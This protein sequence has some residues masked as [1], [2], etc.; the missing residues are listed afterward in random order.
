MIPLTGAQVKV[1]TFILLFRSKNNDVSPSYDEIAKAI[2]AKSKS[3][4]FRLVRSI[5]ERGHIRITPNRVRSIEVVEPKLEVYRK[6]LEKIDDL[7]SIVARQA[8]DAGS[9]TSVQIGVVEAKKIAMR[10]LH[11]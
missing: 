3:S 2:G 5:E 11:G 6:A 1:I 4:V 10:A 9:A 8:H 7:L